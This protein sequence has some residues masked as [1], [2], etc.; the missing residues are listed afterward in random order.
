MYFIILQYIFAPFAVISVL[1]FFL[2]LRSEKIFSSD[3]GLSKSE[4]L[5]LKLKLKPRIAIHLDGTMGKKKLASLTRIK[6]ATYFKFETINTILGTY[7]K[8][9]S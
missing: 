8:T 7:K 2:R 3:L 9:E 5:F 4:Y 1:S 6:S